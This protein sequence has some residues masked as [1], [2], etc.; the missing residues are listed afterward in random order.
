MGPNDFAG[1]DL[2]SDELRYDRDQRVLLAAPELGIGGA[3][4]GWLR[5]AFRAM[6]ELQRL[7]PGSQLLAP[8]LIIAAGRERVTVTEA[9]RDFARRI[10]NVSC[11]VISEAQHEI[12]MEKDAVRAQFWAAFE[13][14][15]KP[16]P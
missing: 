14:F 8:A 13:A 9:C 2:T 10:S 15:V 5:A 7:G 12:L 3:T 4:I 1:N 16:Q 11:I 6:K